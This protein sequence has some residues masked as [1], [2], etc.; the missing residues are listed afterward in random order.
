LL[1]L[2]INFL[3]QLLCLIFLKQLNLIV[4]KFCSLSVSQHIWMKQLWGHKFFIFLPKIWNSKKLL[5]E[6][7]VTLLYLLK[8]QFLMLKFSLI[9]FFYARR[10]CALKTRLFS[11]YLTFLWPLKDELSFFFKVKI[12]LLTYGKISKIG[13]SNNFF[14]V[15]VLF[16]I[17][18]CI[19][20]WFF[21][22]QLLVLI[23]LEQLDQIGFQIFVDCLFSS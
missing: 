2:A 12:P 17:C 10:A 20:H 23:L 13:R 7:L 5:Q 3:S 14:V 22:H 4:F 18:F 19:Q 11:P 9:L 8:W 16:Q 6:T 1:S 21:L 15:V